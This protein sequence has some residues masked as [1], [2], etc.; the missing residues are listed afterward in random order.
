MILNAKVI[1]N[2]KRFLICFN[3]EKDEFKV[4]L[5]SKPENNKANNELVKELK[6]IC[7]CEVKILNGANSRNKVIGLDCNAA[8]LN[9][10]KLNSNS[11]E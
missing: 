7:K 8:V 2:S 10:L 11:V 3:K 1:P 9:S 5:K 4:H 6:K